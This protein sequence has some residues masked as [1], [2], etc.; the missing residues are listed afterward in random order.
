MVLEASGFRGAGGA[1]C[2]P[3]STSSD[4]SRLAAEH[5]LRTPRTEE[6]SA[7]TVRSIDGPMMTGARE[8]ASDSTRGPSRVEGHLLDDPDAAELDA[9]EIRRSGGMPLVQ[10]VIEGNR[11][12]YSFAADRD[13]TIL[14]EVRQISEGTRPPD[15]GVSSSSA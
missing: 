10:E 1:A 3:S 4:L 15:A 2:A 7:A 5:D 8:H 11:E 12:A 13:G 6:A 14:T 9:L